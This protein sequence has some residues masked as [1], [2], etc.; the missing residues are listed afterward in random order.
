MTHTNFRE[1]TLETYK[2]DYVVLVMPAKGFN[3]RE[4]VGDK[5]RDIWK[6]MYSHKPLNGGGV[7]TGM[8]LTTP[9][10]T[11]LQKIDNK[12]PMLLG[13]YTSKET[14]EKVV[15][16]IKAADN[17][18]SVV[19]SGL[20][21]DAAEIAKT[22]GLNL[23][24]IQFA[25]GIHGRRDLLPPDHIREVTTMC[26]HGLISA[27]LV[28]HLLEKVKSNK[29]SIDDAVTELGKQCICGIF[30]TQ[31]AKFLFERALKAETKG[32]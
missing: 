20:I 19:V 10:E 31:K 15:R 3:N 25:L 4:D 11:I 5:L 26:G 6:I 8:L 2:Q 21:E 29:M 27:H 12:T 32:F 16:D 17:G 24:S 7:T 1:G 13:V 30:N 18:I 22:N 23:H 9:A 14:I 28:A